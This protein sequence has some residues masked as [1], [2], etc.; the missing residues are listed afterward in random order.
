[1]QPFYFGTSSQELRHELENLYL[2]TVEKRPAPR[3]FLIENVPRSI[4]GGFR[5]K[6]T[7]LDAQT[8]FQYIDAPKIWQKNEMNKALVPT[9]VLAA[10][11][12]WLSEGCI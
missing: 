12:T 4:P 10:I 8:D 2:L 11:Q 5:E 9:P 1:M 6:L 3:V 7:R